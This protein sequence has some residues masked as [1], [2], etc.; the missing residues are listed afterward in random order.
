MMIKKSLLFILLFCIIG[1]VFAQNSDLNMVSSYLEI[2]KIFTQPI[3]EIDKSKLEKLSEDF[4]R[5][6]FQS[7]DN[8]SET[9]IL[10]FQ[11][12]A[13]KV[14][15]SDP[16]HVVTF[17]EPLSKYPWKFIHDSTNYEMGRT[18]NL[19]GVVM[20]RTQRSADGLVM[21]NL[22]IEYFKR[23]KDLDPTFLPS[24]Y[25]NISGTYGDLGDY[26]KS[27]EYAVE[28][29]RISEELINSQV[30]DES[31][32]Q[33]IGI[34]LTSIKLT[35]GVALFK[36]LDHQ[37]AFQ[38]YQEA[39]IL[40]TKYNKKL[41]GSIYGNLGTSHE[42]QL[43][44][45]EAEIYYRLAIKEAENNDDDITSCLQSVNLLSLYS[46]R[47]QVKKFNHAVEPLRKNL[48]ASLNLPEYRRLLGLTYVQEAQIEEKSKNN[49]HSL[50]LLMTAIQIVEPDLKLWDP[51]SK[52]SNE[53][54]LKYPFL[55]IEIFNSL[56]RVNT[57]IALSS[58]KL[59]VLEKSLAYLANAETIIEFLR[60][61]LSSPESK[62]I[63]NEHQSKTY[64]AKVDLCEN[65]FE[66]TEDKKFIKVMFETF[67][68]GKTAGLWSEIQ[69]ADFKAENI[70]KKLSDDE[71][72]YKN[73]KVQAQN[74]I[75]SLTVSEK[76]DSIKLR[77]LKDEVFLWSTKYD[78]VIS[79]YRKEYP[80][81]FDVKFNKKVI[82]LSELQTI[83]SPTQ[84]FIQFYF[85]RNNLHRLVISKDLVDYRSI[86]NPN[87]IQNQTKQLIQHLKASR[88]DYK[89][90]EV[91]EY[92]EQA[93]GLYDVLL[94][95]IKDL[96]A[97]REIIISGDGV[98]NL[99]PFEALVRNES[100]SE[101]SDFRDFDYLIY[102]HRFSYTYTATL[103]EYHT[104]EKTE[105]R[106]AGHV[107]AFAPVYEK[108]SNVNYIDLYGENLPALPGTIEEVKLIS[109]E[110]RSRTFLKSK[111]TEENFKL[112]IQNSDVLHLAMH[113]VINDDS[114]LQSFLVF[115]NTEDKKEDG[116]LTASEILNLRL[117]SRLA[118]LSAC[119]TGSGV[120][121]EGEGIMGLARSFIQAGCPN[122]ILNLWAM[123][124]NFGKEIINDFYLGVNTG[125]TLSESIQKA[126]IKHLEKS[127]KLASHPHYWA[128]VILLGKDTVLD[129]PQK[130]NY[131]LTVVLIIV[132]LS[133]IIVFQLKKNRGSV[134][135]SP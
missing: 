39:I 85:T 22:A 102:N 30:L 130:R 129:I 55:I 37:G 134:S 81:Y 47:K 1:E 56:S 108:N 94:Y 43:L 90:K 70:P 13:K 24:L 116:R 72:T 87:D 60:P 74:A 50:E 58:N 95:D 51:T 68:K 82:S 104:I 133:L 128:G 21:L 86:D 52:L 131:L 92:Y 115:D 135:K 44:Y 100:I 110:F 2:K 119:N 33:V 20:K 10:E 117:N 29:E 45:D 124:D 121:R 89:R 76:E 8:L 126:K 113:T 40:A 61:T 83:L 71:T 97:G 78:S 111:A 106:H 48:L 18:M 59:K 54:I 127:G 132:A 98:L 31:E 63:L 122:L 103:W 27:L 65:L 93:K 49:E 34:R 107:L 120:I 46:T 75:A 79:I 14:Y 64:E 67:E 114:P 91:Q 53:V 96:I 62:I 57:N 15:T 4:T 11:E 12:Y 66:M 17:L 25:N 38:A 125:M 42:S 32:K 19:L 84:T 16:Q 123:D 80:K 36:I 3:A 118:V 105:T 69:Q 9:W 6:R 23:F 26:S 7:D 88:P 73:N 35:K 28:A 5:D 99:L 112:E 77:I 41:L 109:K 101:R